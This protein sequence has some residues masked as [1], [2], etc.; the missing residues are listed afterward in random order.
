MSQAMPPR[1]TRLREQ[2]TKNE[3][4]AVVLTDP[5]NVGYVTGFTGSTA[6]VF[7]TQAAAVFVADSRYALQAERECPGFSVR[8]CSTGPALME[9][10]A[11]VVKDLGIGTLH[12]EADAVTVSQ[13]ERMKE[14]FA[15]AILAPSRE[16]VE[17]LRL[18]KDPGEI[19]AIREAAGIVDR[20]FDYLLTITRPGV[21]ERDL[22]IELEYF[23][24]KEGSEKE[25]FD[26]IVASGAR[27]AMP[28]GRASEKV[29]E[30]GDF[31]TFDY[32][33]CRHGYFSDLTRTLVLGKASE[34]Q[35]E[36]Y[37]IVLE[38]Q[39]AV[40]KAIRAGRTGKEVDA[41]ARDLIT[42]RGYGEQFGHGTGHGLGREVHD[43]GSLSVRSE[44]T[45]APGM[46]MTVE[47]GIYIDG[48][49]GVR[50]EDD[51]VVTENGCERL[52]HAPKQ[53]IEL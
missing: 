15:P 44:N 26:T 51:V 23:M 9:T 37:G 49:G 42:A 14:V 35:R 18:V 47:P 38:A 33:A 21:R 52:T 1:L 50:I 19:A 7:V 53:L 2:M 31:V 40:L 36:I 48:W 24:K 41:V 20:A 4:G 13:H 45:L 30:P 6:I 8:R 25:A 29:L 3:I 28:H 32:G 17:T 16:L 39:E 11:E 5:I 10:A 34:R 27:S 12:F 43:G 22:A 46:V